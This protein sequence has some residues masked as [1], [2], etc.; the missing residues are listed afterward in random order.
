MKSGMQSDLHLSQPSARAL[1]WLGVVRST[2]PA[3]ALLAALLALWWFA[4]HAQWVS[5]AFVP[6]P[7]ATWASLVEGWREGELA[8]Q[9]AATAQ[10]MAAGFVLASLLG[11]ALGAL[12]GSSARAREWIAPTLEF[13]RPLPASAVLPL[14]IA[15]FGLS[16]GH[17]G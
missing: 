16:P 15:I 12:I 11:V 13:I 9:T 6:T 4:T 2:W 14:A 5:K 10:R 8:A 3:L 1:V 7:E 17:R